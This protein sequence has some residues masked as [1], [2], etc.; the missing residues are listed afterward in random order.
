MLFGYLFGCLPQEIVNR[1]HLGIS[2][3]EG[4]VD[5]D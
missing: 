4:P 5:D 2:H 1:D 3:Y